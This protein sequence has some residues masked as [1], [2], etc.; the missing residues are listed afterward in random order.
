M[1]SFKTNGWLAACVTILQFS[2]LHFKTL[3]FLCTSEIKISQRHVWLNKIWLFL[4]RW[5]NRKKTTHLWHRRR[6]SLSMP[7]VDRFGLCIQRVRIW[8]A[9]LCLRHIVRHWFRMPCVAFDLRSFVSAHLCKPQAWTIC[10]LCHSGL[11]VPYRSECR[12]IVQKK[13]LCLRLIKQQR[14]VLL[15]NTLGLSFALV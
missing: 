7:R 15:S 11:P 5:C 6:D 8:D 14:T 12:I 10:L 9:P 13:E 1:R 4:L 2:Q 3:S